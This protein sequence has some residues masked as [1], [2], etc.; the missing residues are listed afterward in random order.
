[1][2]WIKEV[3]NELSPL[4]KLDNYLIHI[5]VLFKQIEMV[6]RVSRARKEVDVRLISLTG[7]DAYTA[8]LIK[9]YKQ[10]SEL[11]EACIMGSLYIN[12]A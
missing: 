10:V 2:N 5:E 7:I 3:M 6:N 8:L 1:M 11:Q 12:Q 9:R 4:D